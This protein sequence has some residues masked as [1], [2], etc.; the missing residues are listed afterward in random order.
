MVKLSE[1]IRNEYPNISE[2]LANCITMSV[3]KRMAELEFPLEGDDE[4]YVRWFKTVY[5]PKVLQ[6]QFKYY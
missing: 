6:E 4:A 1:T 3:F 2:R 5:T